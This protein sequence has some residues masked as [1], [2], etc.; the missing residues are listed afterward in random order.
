MPVVQYPFIDLA[1]H[2]KV[3]DGFARGEAIVLF[4]AG[5]DRVLWANGAGARLFANRP[6]YDFLEEG[7]NRADVTFR[8]VETT[9]RQLGGEGDARPLTIRIAQGFRRIGV[10]ARVER[11]VTPAGEPAILFSVPTRSEPLPLHERARQMLEGFEDDDTHMAV[12]GKDGAVIAASAGFARLGI[13]GHT[14]RALVTMVGHDAD[15]LMK[16]PIPTGRGYLPAAIGRIC[17]EPDLNLLFVVEMTIGNLDPSEDFA[18]QPAPAPAPEPEI[19]A[20][21]QEPVEAGDGFDTALD[22]VSKIVDVEEE[23]DTATAIEPDDG[24]P[25]AAE[26]DDGEVTPP[27]VLPPIAP[28]AIS[29]MMA[30]LPEKPAGDEEDGFHFNTGTRAIRFVWKIDAE[31]RFSD[32]SGEFARAVGPHAASVRGMAFSDIAHLF[33]LDP[34]GAITELL[35]KRD[36]WSGKTIYWPVEG[37][38]LRVP[39]DLAALPTYTRNREF[40][41]FRGFGIVRPADAMPDP[42]ELGLTLAA[43]AEALGGRTG[44]ADTHDEIGEVPAQARTPE[45]EIAPPAAIDDE[46]NAELL[47]PAP[48]D[49]PAAE[50]PAVDPEAAATDAPS[51]PGEQPFLRM[52]WGEI[53]ALKIM[54][55]PERP[56]PAPVSRPDNRARG[57]ALTPGEQAAFREIARRL[58]KLTQPDSGAAAPPAPNEAA[59]EIADDPAPEIEPQAALTADAGPAGDN[60]IPAEEAT[61]AEPET[62]EPKSLEESLAAIIPA[63]AQMSEGMTPADIDAM[64]MAILVHAGDRLIHANPAFLS[65]TGYGALEEL[66]L[67]GG[68]DALLL[69]DEIAEDAGLTLLRADD[70]LVRVTANLKSIRW[71]DGHALMLSLAPVSPDG[72]AAPEGEAEAEAEVEAEAEAEAEGEGQAQGE[73]RGRRAGGLTWRAALALRSTRRSAGRRCCSLCAKIPAPTSGRSRTPSD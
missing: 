44:A 71:E 46:P 7:P 22:T 45:P 60:G 62:E 38:A 37:T 14:A 72:V 34:D 57:E 25:D 19:P 53:P 48:E 67:V 69:R 49:E 65:L 43:D 5:M 70:G 59:A 1:V 32:V 27:A 21:T 16:R 8:Q 20:V 39:V 23:P 11:I 26:E 54:D 13:T 24:M 50:P 61:A 47:P 33:Q 9:A 31:G 41:G 68:L 52:P 42:L 28:A 29:A 55:A 6:I 35:G 18:P 36:T 56:E 58:E 12:L 2:R 30:A 66:D 4:S 40:D 73:G 15:R 63:R 3:R 51:A 64:P 17:E 10:Q